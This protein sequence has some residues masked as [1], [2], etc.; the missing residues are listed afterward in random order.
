MWRKIYNEMIKKGKKKSSTR[1]CDRVI[2]SKR[3]Q[4]KSH[5]HV[6]ESRTFSKG[7]TWCKLTITPIRR[8]LAESRNHLVFGHNPQTLTTKVV[9]MLYPRDMK[10]IGYQLQCDNYTRTSNVSMKKRYRSI[11][12]MHVGVELLD[13]HG[14]T[15]D[16]DVTQWLPTLTVNDSG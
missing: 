10:H 11:M 14:R 6:H 9:R 16:R 15:G 3:V 13:Q 8:A 12:S 5:H 1:L 4:N 7:W 2:V